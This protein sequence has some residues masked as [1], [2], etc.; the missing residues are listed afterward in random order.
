MN[1]IDAT[2]RE[3]YQ[4]TFIPFTS[5][6]K[7]KIGWTDTQGVITNIATR[8][9]ETRNALVH[10]KSEQAENQ[11]RPYKDKKDLIREIALIRAVAELVII[12][13]SE[14]M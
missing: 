9:Y 8:I 4:N 3:Y 5:S 6:T 12:N 7:T 13:S 10:S 2:A 1:T 14:V 11:Y